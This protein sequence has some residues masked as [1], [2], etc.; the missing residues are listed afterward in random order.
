MLFLGV[1]MGVLPL[2]FESV[3]SVWQIALP[4]V[5]GVIQFSGGLTRTKGGRSRNSLL[6]LS[7][8]LLS[9]DSHRSSSTLVLGFTPLALLDPRPLDS[10]WHSTNSFPKSLAC[11]WQMVGRL[12]LHNHVS[13]FLIININR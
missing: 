12:S 6:L 4:S 13:Q 3:D 10:D 7:I 1:S 5:V 2:A 9:W 11:R 8:C